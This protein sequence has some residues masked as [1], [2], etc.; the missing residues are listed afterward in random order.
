MVGHVKKLK[1]ASNPGVSKP[2]FLRKVIVYGENSGLVLAV[3]HIRIEVKNSKALTIT[4]G[5]ILINVIS[6]LIL[7]QS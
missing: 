7:Q 3:L 1:K 5:L 6:Q 2:G 4:G